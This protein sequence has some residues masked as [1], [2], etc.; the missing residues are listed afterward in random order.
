MP[1]EKKVASPGLGKSAQNPQQ[2]E[3]R[4]PKTR[5]VCQGNLDAGDA[6]KHPGSEPKARAFRS[7]AGLG[8]GELYRLKPRGV[9]FQLYRE[10]SLQ[11]PQKPGLGDVSVDQE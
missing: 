5:G 4:S 2:A 11:G 10:R 3:T 8:Q 9:E 7:E 1:E 6:L